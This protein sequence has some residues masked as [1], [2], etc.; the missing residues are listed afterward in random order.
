MPSRKINSIIDF[1][2]FVYQIATHFLLEKLKWV[3]QAILFGG[4][5]GVFIKFDSLYRILDIDEIIRHLSIATISSFIYIYILQKRMRFWETYFHE[6]THIV[7]SV[8]T[9][10]HISGMEVHTR[11]G[12][13]AISKG[14]SNWLI[15]L[16]PYCVSIHTI[17]LMFFY[18]L[19]KNEYIEHLMVVVSIS[20]AFYLVTIFKQFSL[21]QPDIYETGVMFS[22]VAVVQINFIFLISYLNI[23]GGDM[24]VMYREIVEGVISLI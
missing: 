1:F 6:L 5:I 17:A 7:F 8:L 23:I 10:N 9:L 22:I 11:I 16:S 4:V 14:V 19:I 3:I 24:P 21:K 13:Q 20:Y 18:H 12:G 2:I 15:S